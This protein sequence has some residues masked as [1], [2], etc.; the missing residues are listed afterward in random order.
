MMNP[1][2]PQHSRCERALA[3]AFLAA[4]LELLVRRT[5]LAAVP[6]ALPVVRHPLEHAI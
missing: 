3:A 6:A 4:A 5:L 2:L 1:Y